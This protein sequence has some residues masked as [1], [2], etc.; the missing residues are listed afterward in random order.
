MKQFLFLL[1]VLLAFPYATEAQLIRVNG[2][3]TILNPTKAEDVPDDLKAIQWKKY[4]SKDYKPA[5]I[6]DFKERAYLRYNIFEDQME[7]VKDNNIYYLKKDTGRKIRFSDN[8]LYKVYGLKGKPQFFLVHI[9]GKNSLL[10]KQSVRF[11]EAKKATSGYD[12]DKPADYK[13]RKDVLYLAVEGKGLV[14]IPSKKKSFYAVFGNHASTVKSY[15]KEHKLNYKKVKDL[16][17]LVGYMNT[18]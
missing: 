5:Y 12:K 10:A 15:M 13:R 17:K 3:E 16:T 2:Y 6:D 14:E 7:F 8:T 1:A 9:D 4:Q 18:L 11:V